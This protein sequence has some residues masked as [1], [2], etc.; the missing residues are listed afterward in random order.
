MQ[1]KPKDFAKIKIVE[2][3]KCC[4]LLCT[5]PYT[6]TAVQVNN[7]IMNFLRITN[8]YAPTIAI[9]YFWSWLSLYHI[10]SQLDVCINFNHW[11]EMRW[12]NLLN[13]IAIHCYWL[14]YIHTYTLLRVLISIQLSSAAGSHVHQLMNQAPKFSMG[15]KTMEFNSAY[16][17]SRNVKTL[18]TYD[19]QWSSFY[20]DSIEQYTERLLTIQYDFP[21]LTWCNL[22]CYT[23]FSH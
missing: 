23:I 18:G 2:G 16:I 13:V 8:K 11:N 6:I 4:N 9:D 10:I 3:R 14:T 12:T 7:N 1:G 21:C 15:A 22:L 5:I 20:I 17:D 19:I